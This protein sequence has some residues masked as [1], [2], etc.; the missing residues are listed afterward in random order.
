MDN[1]RRDFLKK[2]TLATAGITIGSGVNAMTAQSYNNI[3]GANDRIN[4]AIQGLGRRYGAFIDGIIAKQ[5]NARISYLCDVM[6]SQMDKALKKV[7][8]KIKY[9]PSLEEDIRKILDDKEVD[10]VFMATPDHWHTPG[11][12]MAMKAGKHVYLEKPCSHNPHENELVVA[13]Q[14]KY[15]KVVQMGNQQ[16]SS[17]QSIKIIK[18]I[19]DGKIGEAY[20]AI[21]FYANARGKVPLPVKATPPNGLNWDLFQGPSPRKDYTHDTWNYNW[22]WY[23]WDFGTAEMG[24]NATHELDI[25]R[26]ALNVNYPKHVEAL[27]WKN[28]FQDDGWEMYDE[29]LA[30]YTFEKDK[31]IQWDGVSRNS[32]KKYGKARGT[33]IMGTEG[34]AMIDRSGYELFDRR[35]E[36]IDEWK[37]GSSEG[38]VALG[39]GGNLSTMHTVNFFNAIRGKEALTSPIEIGAM[40]QMLTH[41]ANISYRVNKGFEVDEQ[42]GRIYDKEAMKL[43]SRQYEPGWEPKL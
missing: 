30:T 19:H 28:H 38:G 9:K 15:N 2:A 37:S 7:G 14:K 31:V 8:E 4:V 21:A 6:P 35:G 10:A 5:S 26:W 43:W 11:A 42:T 36:K 24:N 23:G 25:A 17:A 18:E 29:M 22:H 34:S 1:K 3:I 16:R 12:I 27:G 40:S 33:I 41:Y 39:G 13:A 20:K 32:Y